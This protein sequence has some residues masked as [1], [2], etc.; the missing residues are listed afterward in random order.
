VCGKRNT[1][2]K[3]VDRHALDLKRARRCT[4]LR[5]ERTGGGVVAG[6]YLRAKSKSQTCCARF[7]DVGV[8]GI[9]VRGGG[10]KPG[11]N[12]RPPREPL[13]THSVVSTSAS[14]GAIWSLSR[15]CVDEAMSV[16]PF[17]G[18][19]CSLLRKG[20]RESVGVVSSARYHPRIRVEEEMESRSRNKRK[21]KREREGERPTGILTLVQAH[22]HIIRRRS[23]VP[24]GSIVAVFGGGREGRGRHP[25]RS[26]S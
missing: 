9:V 2:E 19:R 16:P 7:D 26:T 8:R 21:R 17:G 10:G 11:H 20:G 22:A 3:R 5:C 4:K 6:G 1:R 24:R 12:F 13:Q 18:G 23:L 15:P 14:V 25:F